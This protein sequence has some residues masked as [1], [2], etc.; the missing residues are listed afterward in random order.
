MRKIEKFAK[1]F[2][3]LFDNIFWH[4]VDIAHIVDILERQKKKPIKKQEKKARNFKN[5]KKKQG[6]KI[7]EI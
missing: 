2:N 1:V 5:K 3:S 4:S 6:K 7:L